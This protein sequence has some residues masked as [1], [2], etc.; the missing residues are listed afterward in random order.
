MD[1]D[2]LPAVLALYHLTRDKDASCVTP[3]LV[4]LRSNKEEAELDFIFVSSNQLHA[5]ECKAGVEIGDKDLKTARLA[6]ELGI[7]HF[8]FCTV[9]KFTEASQQKI[10][11]L[12]TELSSAKLAT[13]VFVLTGDDL[14]GKAIESSP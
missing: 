7:D 10:E 3:G 5:G 13:D 2:A 1:Q 11:A 9:R 8:Y 12:M 6:A 4:L 14:L